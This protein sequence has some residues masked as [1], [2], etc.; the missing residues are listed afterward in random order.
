MKTTSLDSQYARAR[1]AALHYLAR[2]EHSAYELATKLTRRYTA[3]VVG[4]L[5]DELTEN[6]ELQ[7]CAFESI[8]RNINRLKE[9]SNLTVT[10]QGYAA[11]GPLDWLAFNT[12]DGKTSDVRVR[13]AIAYAIDK[14]FI[15]KAIMLG[16]AQDA[17]TGIYPGGPNYEPNVEAYDVDL[18]KANKILENDESDMFAMARAFLSNPRWVWDAADI[19]GTEIETPNQYARRF[20]KSI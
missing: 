4:S 8:A 2:R 11:I 3:A 18:D 20:K 9:N 6:G 14:N 13:K 12:V 16:T 19:L 7:F 5:V 17:K 15:L 1:S 10:P